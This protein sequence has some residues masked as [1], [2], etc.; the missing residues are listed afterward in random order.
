MNSELP[1]LTLAKD[2]SVERP[3][4]RLLSTH[5]L[6]QDP[7]GTSKSA[8][9][10][11]EAALTQDG[12]PATCPRRPSPPAHREVWEPRRRP[13]RVWPRTSLL[14]SGSVSETK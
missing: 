5:P 3:I 2:G 9:P 6:A 11:G 13:N 1:A 7:R 14:K 8:P 4:T 10:A 12:G